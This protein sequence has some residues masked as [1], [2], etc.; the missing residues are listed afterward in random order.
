MIK[1][2]INIISKFYVQCKLKLKKQ[3]KTYSLAAGAILIASENANAVIHHTDLGYG[4]VID[5]TNNTF[6]IDFGNNDITNFI[7]NLVS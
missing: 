4:A 7:I 6:E 5:S 3:L 1:N 2:V